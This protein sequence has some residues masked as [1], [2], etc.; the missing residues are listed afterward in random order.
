LLH[1]RTK[2]TLAAGLLLAAGLTLAAC[3]V[4]SE[5]SV[6]EGGGL[7]QPQVEA[8]VTVEGQ[9]TLETPETVGEVNIGADM[10][11]GGTGEAAAG[12]TDQ[13]MS[14]SEETA[15]VSGQAT[16]NLIAQL[17]NQGATVNEA[18][19]LQNINL[20]LKGVEIMVNGAAVQVFEFASAD[21]AS[22]EAQNIISG[23]STAA[24]D[25]LLGGAMHVYQEGKLVVL[26]SGGKDD[27]M[28]RLS[29]A[30]GAEVQAE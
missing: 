16:I 9:T 26:Y 30:L 11:V 17:R 23:E 20:G 22:A 10:E 14:G 15:Q 6:E 13:E 4:E 8:G 29:D 25:E 19:A 7:N 18:G 1:N 24:L 12:D 21:E 3:N 5:G 2:R 28:T 27:V